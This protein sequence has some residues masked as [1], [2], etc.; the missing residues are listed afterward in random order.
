MIADVTVPGLRPDLVGQRVRVRLDVGTR[1][2]I[3]VP[4]AYIAHRYGLDYARVVD[5]SGA[6]SDV[7]VQLTPTADPAK[8]EVLSGLSDGDVLA[9]AGA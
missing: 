5:R 4:R 6:A 1:S 9:P 3:V 8:V 7:A 2:A